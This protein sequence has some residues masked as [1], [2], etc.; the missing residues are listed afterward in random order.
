MGAVEKCGTPDPQSPLCHH[1]ALG[2]KQPRHGACGDYPPK[3]CSAH[4]AVDHQH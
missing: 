4:L 1:P 2:G 3:G